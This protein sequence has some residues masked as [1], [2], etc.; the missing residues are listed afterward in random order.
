MR[1]INDERVLRIYIYNTHVCAMS[2]AW[3]PGGLLAACACTY[4]THMCA[5]SVAWH[6]CTHVRA[7]VSR[8]CVPKARF[9]FSLDPSYQVLTMLCISQI[10]PPRGQSRN[11]SVFHFSKHHHIPRCVN[12]VALLN[13]HFLIKMRDYSSYRE[14]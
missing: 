11:S 13:I 1:I 4:G 5:R 6:I 2:V 10:F 14:N 9:S 8:T 12:L 7:E 3:Y